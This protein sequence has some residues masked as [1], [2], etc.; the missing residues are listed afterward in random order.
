MDRRIDI[1]IAL[2]FAVFGLFLIIHATSIPMG[3]YK[4]PVGP[5][6]FFYVFGTIMSLGGL[7]I[8]AQGWRLLQREGAEMDPNEG[9]PDESGY[10]GSW[11]RA[12]AIVAIF[13]LYTLLFQPLGYII[14]TPLCITASLYVLGQRQKIAI[15]VIALVFTTL[16][17]LIFAQVLNVRVPVGPFTPLFREL[18][19]IYT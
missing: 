17:Y 7:V 13:I 19:W 9:S 6:K 2:T 3:I 14:S 4:D 18:G 10:P 1:A 5:R 16:S 11:Q 8:A 15:P 12:F